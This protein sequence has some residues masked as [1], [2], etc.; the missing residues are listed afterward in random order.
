[1]QEHPRRNQQAPFV[2]GDDHAEIVRLAHDRR[3]AGPE[4]AVIHLVHQVEMRLR[5]ICI[6]IR[7]VM[8]HSARQ[9][10]CRL[11]RRVRSTPVESAIVVSN[12]TIDG[13]TCCASRRAV[14]SARRTIGVATAPVD[15]NVTSR[16]R[17]GRHSPAGAV[18]MAF[19]C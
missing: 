1:M 19:D 5:M 8:P 13:R 6:V 17:L 4:N 10:H 12:W 11:D 9:S 14:R 2:I 15:P 7:S 3:I 18:R 16:L